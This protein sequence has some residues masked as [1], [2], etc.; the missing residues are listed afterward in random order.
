MEKGKDVVILMYSLIRIARG[1]ENPMRGRLIRSGGINTKAITET[2]KLFG[3]VR[4]VE[5]GGSLTILATCLIETESRMDDVIF[6]ELKGT[7]NMEVRLDQL[8]AEQRIY[9]AI[10]IPQS[11]TRNDDRLYHPDELPRVLDIRRHLAAL[12]IGE[13][14]ET[15][16]SGLSKTKTNAELLLKGLR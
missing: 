5:D 1:Y 13:A 10:H 2:R 8:L 11:G 6:E 16:L 7:G 4:N 12:P 3:S 14:I 15:L 9:P